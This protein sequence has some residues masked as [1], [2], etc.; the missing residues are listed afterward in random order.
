M[1]LEFLIIG[2]IGLFVVT[3]LLL[4]IK[5]CYYPACFFIIKFFAARLINFDRTRNNVAFQLAIIAL[6]FIIISF[7]RS[8]KII[9]RKNAFYKSCEFILVFVTFFVIIGL[10][11]GHQWFQVFIDA[12]KYIEILVYYLLFMLC[13]DNNKELLNGLKAICYTML[14]LGILEIFLT[15][16]GGIGLNLI[17]GFFP[18]I[19]LLSIQGYIRHCKFIFV[20]SIMV[21]VLCQTRT[22]IISFLFG[23]ILLILLTPTNV[24]DKVIL[25]SI[26]L[27][28]IGIVA[29]SLFG[30]NLLDATLS[31]FLQLAAGFEESGGYRIDEY[32]VALQKFLMHPLIGNGFG[33]LEYTFINKLGFVKW[34]DFIHCLYIEV[35]FKT[36]ILGFTSIVFI[37]KKFVSKIVNAMSKF[38]GTDKFMF[39][40]CCGGVCSFAT[41]ALTYAFAPLTTY[42][43]MFVGIL[44]AGV[45]ISNYWNEKK[46][47]H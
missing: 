29:I 10:I 14:T 11:Y 7:K 35:L 38:K 15:S 34:G 36:G 1:S 2:C 37:V 13:W 31:R 18:I 27:G 39:A 12:Y 41:W 26:S 20:I 42:G 32:K 24:R 22:Y 25:Y 45:A 23:L 43:S 17:M 28:L 6:I 16:R 30:S 3:F 4:N 8:G 44:T 21:V 9:I 5:T 40:V 33:Y 19:L 46:I 47:G